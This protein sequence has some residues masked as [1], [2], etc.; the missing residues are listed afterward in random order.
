MRAGSL[1][2]RLEGAR[3]QGREMFP[4]KEVNRVK[5]ARS[6]WRTQDASATDAT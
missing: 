2:S 4:V 3:I 1:S 6:A 5:C